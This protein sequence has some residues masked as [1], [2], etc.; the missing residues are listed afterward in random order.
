MAAA[1]LILAG[2]GVMLGGLA[3]LLAMVV[4]VV[5][6][7]LGLSLLAYASAFFGM[8]LGLSGAVR[9]VRRRR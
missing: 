4:G 8:L 2:I 6:S 3:L 9:V 1:V 7:A 5:P